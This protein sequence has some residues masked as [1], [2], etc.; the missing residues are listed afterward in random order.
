M[1]ISSSYTETAK[2]LNS[3]KLLMR[4]YKLGLRKYS[5]EQTMLVLKINVI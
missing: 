2:N 1:C 3:A 5:K 4:E